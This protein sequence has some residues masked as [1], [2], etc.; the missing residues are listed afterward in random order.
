M[1]KPSTSQLLKPFSGARYHPECRLVIWRPRGVLNDALADRVVR[2]VELETCAMGEPFDRFTDF[3]GLTEIRLK[4]GH[5]FQLAR[6]LRQD[7][8]GQPV[9][10]AFFSE[11]TVGLGL[12]RMYEELMQDA[13]SYV[14][15]FRDLSMAARW[16]GVPTE[17]LRPPS[18]HPHPD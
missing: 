15:A 11:Q 1:V 14:R 5:A 7:H 16:L 13:V 9:K 2:F 10:A 6:S 4:P 18:N 17:L 8:P 12:A 3:S